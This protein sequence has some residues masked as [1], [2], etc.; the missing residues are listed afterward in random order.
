MGIETHSQTISY[1]A[2]SN[3]FDYACILES[4]KSIE[5]AYTYYLTHYYKKEQLTKSEIS[6][7]CS[8][9]RM[10]WQSFCNAYKKGDL[11]K[12]LSDDFDEGEI[13]EDVLVNVHVCF[14]M[15][16]AYCGM[17]KASAGKNDIW[18]GFEK[19]LDRFVDFMNFAKSH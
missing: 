5:E 11:P 12:E 13:Y 8:Q 9:L 14:D 3:P 1:K 6:N 4:D 18:I 17:M 15:L 2:A 16:N 10:L 7:A 19:E